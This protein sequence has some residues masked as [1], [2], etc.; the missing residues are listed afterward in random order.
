MG[1]IVNYSV[2]SMPSLSDRLI[3]TD[4][5]SNN[6]TKNFLI[7]DILALGGGG[8]GGYVPYVGAIANVNLGL[9]DII[10]NKIIKS[11]G[12]TTQFLKANGDIDNTTYLPSSSLLGY[13]PYSGATDNVHLGA[14]TITANKIIKS[15]GLTSQFLKANGD[16]DSTVYLPASSAYVPKYASYYDTTTQT[17][18][19][20]G[21]K[22][23]QFNTSNFYAGITIANDLLGNP[24]R[25]T[26]DETGTYN[27]QFSAQ[28]VRVSGGSQKRV[29]IWVKTNGVDVPW[30]ATVATVEAN[31]HQT[32]IG[33]NFFIYMTNAQY[34]EIWWSQDDEITFATEPSS[35]TYPNVPS[36][37]LT[38]SKVS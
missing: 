22:A 14:Y 16:I 19:S 12:T 18:V 10:A 30:S 11:G 2:N 24:T 35:L 15:G 9:Y 1:K 6:E 32:V 21:S 4:V 7:S 31:S 34:S 29:V 27:I 36:I 25:I 33:W 26:V 37:I 23:M 20:G 28:V 13:V 3:G 8:G 38:V 17:V 5:D